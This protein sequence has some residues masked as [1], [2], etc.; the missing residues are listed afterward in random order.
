MY[1]TF[2][3][4]IV[5]IGLACFCGCRQA[6]HDNRFAESWDR[7]A[8][9][10]FCRDCGVIAGKAT[11]CPV[12]EDGH[13]FQDNNPPSIIVCRDCGA[14]PSHKGTSCPANEDGHYFIEYKSGE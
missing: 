13:F 2:W 6:N 8:H 4:C 3:F 7:T 1:K 14:M 10:V 9:I 12:N 5:I 11:R